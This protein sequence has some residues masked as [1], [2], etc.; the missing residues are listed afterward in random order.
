MNDGDSS[1]FVPDAVY[2]GMRLGAAV[3]ILREVF[4]DPDHKDRMVISGLLAHADEWLAMEQQ[5][6][7]ESIKGEQP[8]EGYFTM[9]E[10]AF[11]RQAQ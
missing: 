3:S 8:P 9:N 6:F 1:I 7:P 2:E 10:S 5:V 4:L 11:N